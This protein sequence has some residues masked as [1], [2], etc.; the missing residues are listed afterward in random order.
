MV[1]DV[2]LSVNAYQCHEQLPVDIGGTTIVWHCDIQMQQAL[3]T[4][5]WFGANRFFV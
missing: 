1:G 5:V 2:A 3:I 4:L